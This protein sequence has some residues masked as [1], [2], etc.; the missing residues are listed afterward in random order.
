MVKHM[1]CNVP[2]CDKEPRGKTGLCYAHYMRN[3]RYG[4]PTATRRGLPHRDLVGSRFG[5][6]VVVSYESSGR[7][8]CDCDCG[9]S[10]HADTG[11]LNRGSALTCGD[12][13]THY[14]G[15]CGYGAMHDRLR[16]DRGSASQR[17]CVDCGGPAR[18]WS[19]DHL[20]PEVLVD[21]RLG[22]PYSRKEEHYEPRC[23]PCHKLFDLNR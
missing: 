17:V 9:Q 13:R 4:S 6:L 18:H 1:V 10:C 5:S 8:R 16:R 7:W 20:D 15:A 21:A 19:Y 12:K 14:R 2:E 3:Y 22:I 11:A 23:V